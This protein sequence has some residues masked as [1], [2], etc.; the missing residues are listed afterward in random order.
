MDCSSH[1]FLLLHDLPLVCYAP[2]QLFLR[3]SSCPLSFSFFVFCFFF[4]FPIFLSVL[5]AGGNDEEVGG[6]E[7]GVDVVKYMKQYG[8]RLNGR[9]PSKICLAGHV[10]EISNVN[11][12]CL[13]DTNVCSFLN[14]NG[15]LGERCDWFLL[16]LYLYEQSTCLL[17]QN[18]GVWVTFEQRFATFRG[19]PVSNSLQDRSK[20]IGLP[21]L[22]HWTFF[23]TDC[24][25]LFVSHRIRAMLLRSWAWRPSGRT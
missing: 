20:V 9:G 2:F 7:C 18:A 21:C 11:N 16:S 23:V 24:F 15:I 13:R 6:G 4:F 12:R 22:N 17:L 3:F 8:N 25:Y 14:F 5:P 10:W 1:A 19:F